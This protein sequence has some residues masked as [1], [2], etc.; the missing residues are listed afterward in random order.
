MLHVGPEA[1]IVLQAGRATPVPQL[2]TVEARKRWEQNRGR[3][4]GL[5]HEHAVP[6]NQLIRWMLERPERPAPADVKA[7]LS[8]LCFAV[9]V[10]VEEDN[11]LRATG[12]KDSLP[13]GWDWNAKGDER[14]LR[15]AR[16]RL[17]EAVRR[18]D[19][20]G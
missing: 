15:Y 10:T 20:A 14:L 3:G 13:D 11:E 19:S 18:P 9:V 7:F 16:A 5:R 4:A 12:F 6:R 1:A 17:L 2:H 8:R